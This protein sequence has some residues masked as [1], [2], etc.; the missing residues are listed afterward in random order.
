M[1][2]QEQLSTTLCT[3]KTD[4]WP[5]ITGHTA[6]SID[7]YQTVYESSGRVDTDSSITQ[8]AQGLVRYIYLCRKVVTET[9]E[10]VVNN[11]CRQA[12]WRQ[13]KPR[14]EWKCDGLKKVE[15]GPD[16]LLE[17]RMMSKEVKR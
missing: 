7:V 1:A 10:R 11:T 15:D 4:Y 2:K 5:R 13:S 8:K 6:L 17:W 14:P 16:T 3:I 12:P 9:V